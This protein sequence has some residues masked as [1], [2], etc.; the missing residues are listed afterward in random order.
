MVDFIDLKDADHRRRVVDRLRA[1]AESDSVPVWVGAMSRLGLVELTRR[2]RGRTLS[3]I[4]TQSC[5]TCDGTGRVRQP[6][7]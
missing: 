6:R 3:E 4:M 1:A 7:R 2:R 5:T